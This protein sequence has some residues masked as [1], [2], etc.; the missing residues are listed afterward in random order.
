M[1]IFRTSLARSVPGLE[2][3]LASKRTWVQRK[4][5]SFSFIG[6]RTAAP[7]WRH[8]SPMEV[9]RATHGARIVAS[10]LSIESCKTTAEFWPLLLSRRSSIGSLLCRAPMSSKP[11]LTRSLDGPSAISGNYGRSVQRFGS[12]EPPAIRSESKHGRLS[13][14]RDPRRPLSARVHV[15][16]APRLSG[17]PASPESI[18]VLGKPENFA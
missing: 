14:F 4:L 2:I 17:A 18:E 15:N 9:S 12:R 3:D 13:I 1:V 11:A 5:F 16:D 8:S 7:R 6:G 10:K